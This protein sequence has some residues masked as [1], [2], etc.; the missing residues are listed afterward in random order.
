MFVCDCGYLVFCCALGALDCGLFGVLVVGVGLDGVDCWD[1]MVAIG[2]LIRP[3]PGGYGRYGL[4]DVDVA[5]W[6]LLG[7]L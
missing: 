5:E 2:M 3:D 1:P 7:I 6:S 4:D